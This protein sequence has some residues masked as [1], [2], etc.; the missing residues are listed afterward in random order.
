[1][2][3]ESFRDGLTASPCLMGC[4]YLLPDVLG[5]LLSSQRIGSVWVCLGTTVVCLVSSLSLSVLP[6][7]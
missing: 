5:S 7:P 4:H 2:E 6:E 3:L 1:M